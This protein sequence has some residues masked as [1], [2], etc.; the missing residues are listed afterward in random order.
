MPRLIEIDPH[1]GFCFGVIKAIE[2][3]E[4]NVTKGP[5]YSLGDIVH[6]NQEVKRL[7]DKGLTPLPA[8][9]LSGISK[10]RVLFRAH[11]EPPSSYKIAKEK[12]LEIIDATCPVVLKLQQ[13]VKNAWLSLKPLDGQIVIF[14]KKGHA[15]VIGLLGQ[16][17]NEAIV[18]ENPDN[19]EDIDFT[20]PI[21]LF[22]QTTKSIEGLQKLITNIEQRMAPGVNFQHHDTICRQVANRV[23]RIR[24][25]AAK[26]D[27]VIFVGGEKSSNAKVLFEVCKRSNP[28]SYFISKPE[29]IDFKWVT[30]STTSVGICGA[31]ST[32]MWQLELVAS[33]IGELPDN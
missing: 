7:E 18:V 26:H 14:G 4:E 30:P 9:G 6:N 3:A 1:S 5:L 10:S 23:P 16:V 15:E 19:L 8:D 28:L 33:I 2:K 12:G 29:D 22:S 24:E 31:T 11:G 27:V 17:N 13:R 25:F 20:K 21:E 32:P